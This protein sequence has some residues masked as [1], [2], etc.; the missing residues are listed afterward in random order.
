[1][2]PPPAP[3][4]GQGVAALGI[5]IAVAAL[6]LVYLAITATGHLGYTGEQLFQIAL[7]SGA[8]LCTFGVVLALR[9]ATRADRA[10]QLSI[11]ALLL[12]I[13]ML[14]GFIVIHVLKAADLY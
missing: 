1:M 11:V 10:T 13:S 5:A 6:Q 8:G 2:T 9:G 14:I 12:N 7:F 4:A 3:P